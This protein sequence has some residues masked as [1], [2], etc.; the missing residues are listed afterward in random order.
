M[1]NIKF[2]RT[3]KEKIYWTLSWVLTA[4]LM[5][6]D[7]L[8]KN[9]VL[10]NFKNGSVKIFDGF[11]ITLSFNRGVSFGFLNF[12]QDRLFYILSIFIAI[13]TLIFLMYTSIMFKKGESTW[14]NFFILAGAFSNLHDRFL[15]GAV[16]DFVDLYI[17]SWHWPIFNLA[18]VFIVFGVFGLL[19]R[20]FYH[21]Y[22]GKN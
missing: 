20:M 13:F 14:F 9:F 4:F 15:Y 18:D 17:K 8:S 22:F 3:K 1:S 7:R 6:L 19:G 12:S 16:I 2:F 5:T 21:D 10:D 11:D